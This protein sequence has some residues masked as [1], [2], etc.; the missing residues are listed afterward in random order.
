MAAKIGDVVFKAGEAVNMDKLWDD[1]ALIKA[2]EK[3]VNSFKLEM[4][5]ESGIVNQA[6]N[7][8]GKKKKRRRKSKK[9]EDKS[10]CDEVNN[11]TRNWSVGDKC[12]AVYSEDGLIY[13]AE[14]MEICSDMCVVRYFD[15]GN[16][17][18]QYLT[19]LMPAQEENLTYSH[20]NDVHSDAEGLVEPNHTNWK[21]S[22]LC[23]APE[24]PYQH[25][26]EA[27]INSFSS[28]LTCKVT[29]VRSRKSHEVNV[30]DLQRSCDFHPSSSNA[31]HQPFYNANL[32]PP[33]PPFPSHEGFRGI[34]QPPIPPPPPP[35]SLNDLQS[36]D[37]S[38]ASMLMSWY[39]S[40]YHT[41][42]FKA[43]QQFKRNHSS[44]CSSEF[45]SQQPYESNVNHSPGTNM[46]T[47]E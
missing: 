37:E 39:L 46:D 29:F 15:Y 14:V 6:N 23:V 5:G 44:N 9:R 32:I 45:T 43:V 3:A 1:S 21:V 30:K 47:K 2:Y 22:D 42:Y 12:L 35:I 4:E 17:E 40:G 41:G 36:D 34:P 10:S 33:M 19:D 8:N 28:S 26:H 20:Q 13:D 18:Q 38:L 27:V 7:P 25:Y 16:E 11:E 31:N 24:P